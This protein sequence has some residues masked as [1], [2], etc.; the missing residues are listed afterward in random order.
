VTRIKK[1]LAIARV[2]C[3]SGVYSRT[4]AA[5]T[6]TRAESGC[7]FSSHVPL[8]MRY[9][10]QVAR[11]GGGSVRPPLPGARRRAGGCRT[12]DDAWSCASAG[13]AGLGLGSR[14]AGATHLRGMFVE[15]CV[16]GGYCCGNLRAENGNGQSAPDELR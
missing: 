12:S 14:G 4:S 2:G 16:P 11:R 9:A 3:M 6:R 13:A 5:N 8:A 15:L 7:R 1:W 10:G